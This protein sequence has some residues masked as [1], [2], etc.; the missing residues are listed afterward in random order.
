MEERSSK[1]FARDPETA[2][3]EAVHRAPVTKQKDLVIVQWSI[4]VATGC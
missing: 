2:E 1:F 3:F 4:F